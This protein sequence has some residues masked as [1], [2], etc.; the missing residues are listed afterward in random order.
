M[1]SRSQAVSDYRRRRKENLIRVCGSK[2]NI[3]GYNRTNS[4]LEFHHIN[5]EKKNYGISSKGT[6]HDLEKDLQEVSKCILV[7]ANCH[8][9]IYD[10]LYSKEDL[11]KY[12]IFDSQVA[13]ELRVD[14]IKKHCYCKNCGKEISKNK[15][16]FC[17]EC[18]LKLH[19][20]EKEYPD[21]EQLK[22][23]IREYS[24]IEIGR[25]YGVTDNAI[26]KWCKKFGLPFR[27]IDILQM[28]DEDWHKI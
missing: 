13:D 25:M 27:K 14:K 17:Y 15:Y 12:Q 24:F 2:C 28:N 6:C 9:E 4:V 7:C 16:G 11:I 19:W 10:G 26:R 21:R 22:N 8:R 20:D 23:L 1:D 5:P 3:C 18:F